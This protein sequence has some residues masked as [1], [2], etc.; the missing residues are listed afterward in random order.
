MQLIKNTIQDIVYGA[1]QL[2]R[3]PLVTITAVLTLAIGIGANTTILTIGNGLLFRKPSGVANPE[4]LIDI[5]FTRNGEGFSSGSYPNYADIRRRST[6][7]EGVYAHPRFPS[8]MRLEVPGGSA[9]S[10]FAFRVTDN[11]FTVLGAVPA[12]GRL[13]VPGDAEGSVVVLSHGFWNRRFGGDPGIVGRTLQLDGRPLTVVGIAAERFHGTGIR[14]A[15]VWVPLPQSSQRGGAVLLVGGRLKPGVS[16][17]QAM[18]ELN[19]LGR[20]LANEYPVENRE[21]GLTA[22]RLSPMPGET[23]PVTVFLALLIGIAMIV[24]AIACANIAGVL[25]ARAAGRRREI[26]VRVA[27]GAGRSRILRQL[28]TETALLFAMGSLVGIIFGRGMASF[29]VSE[30]PHLPFPVDIA[31]ALDLRIIAVSL[32]ISLLAALL[33]GLTP[34]L[35]AS[36]SDVVSGLKGD[37]PNVFNRLRGRRAFLVAQVAFSL[38]LLAVAGL[39]TRALYEV[40]RA[41]PGFDTAG[42]ELASV[43]LA[44]AGHNEITAPAT[45]RELVQRIRRLP[46]VD[47]ATIAAVFPGGFEGIGLGGLEVAGVQP[48]NG[49]PLF[50]PAW[51]IVE[52]GYFATLRMPLLAGRDFNTDDRKG[53]QEVVIIGEGAARTFWPGQN[54]VGRAVQL[55]SWSPQGTLSRKPLLVVGVV[56]DPKFGSLIDGTTGI[57]AYVPLQQEYFPGWTTL[58]VRSTSGRRLTAEIRDAVSSTIPGLPILS[59]QTAAEYADLGLMPQRVTAWV[60]GSLGFVGL[61]LAGIGI[62]GVTAQM[63]TLRTR[64]IGIR[65]A[66]GATRTDVLVMTLKQGMSAVVIGTIAGVLLAAAASRILVV[67]LLGISPLDPVVLSAAAGLCLLA[68]LTACF[69]PAYRAAGVDAM[70][71]LG[72]EV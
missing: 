67:F 60:A 70:R 31:P 3:R 56:R 21:M 25:L 52:P 34:A 47:S 46:G 38:L 16:L 32:T 4:R 61:L 41:D 12:A 23:V 40:S 13:L 44:M 62:Y 28:F 11:Y 24:L 22:A 15:D 35:Q 30:L 63:M 49:E 10:I 37:T 69:L 2:R 14:S 54:A 8:A 18:A 1:R 42:V 36:K 33:S 72:N 66:L 53:T 55:V 9:E 57:Y 20:N 29:L 5:G 26:A 43:N 65:V 19:V 17:A 71:A 50:S 64:E 68:G 6:T 48:P 39:F 59:S 45:A 51:N 7:L 27:V 58:A